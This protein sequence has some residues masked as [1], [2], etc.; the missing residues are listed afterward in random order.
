MKRSFILILLTTLPALLI[1][2]EP[3]AFG[4]G[5]LNDPN[6]YGLTSSEK[7]LL[8]TKQTLSKVSVKSNN[9]ANELDSLRDR[10]DGIQGIIESMSKKTYENKIELQKLR[11]AN[12]QKSKTSDE[13]DKRLSEFV[14]ANSESIESLKKSV[15]HL[16]SVVD[17]IS[18]NHVTKAEFNRL[19]KDINAFKA[20]LTKELSATPTKATPATPKA[21]PKTS[22]SNLSNAE[23]Y[24]RAQSNFDKKNYTL[25][26]EDYETLI[27]AN[28][29]PAYANYMI[30]EMNFRRKNYANAIFYFKNSSSLYAEASYMPTLLLHT[31]ISMDKTGD[32]AN[33]Q[34]F[35][36]AIVAKY[37][38]SS[39]AK[40]AKQSLR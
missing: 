29:K 20:S 38:N 25:A 15:A 22:S 3:S 23:L 19:V 37:P 12:D 33:A 1:S 13:Y 39:E 27:A 17:T 8:E 36:K 28:Y 34:A 31:A 9:Q 18:K 4:A 30:G 21:T 26:I 14:Q 11:E 35:Y 16:S 10:I 32:S 2:S 6:P 7:V 5:D 40:K 24:Q